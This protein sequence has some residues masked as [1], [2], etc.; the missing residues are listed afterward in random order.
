[1]LLLLLDINLLDDDLLNFLGLSQ[2][3]LRYQLLFVV[4]WFEVCDVNVV[5]H[6]IVHLIA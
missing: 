1:M 6:V 2:L 4:S 3:Q 5:Q